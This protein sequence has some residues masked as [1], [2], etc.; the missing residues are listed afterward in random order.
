MTE[1]EKPRGDC[2]TQKKDRFKVYMKTIR[3]AHRRL[4]K[5]A[6]EENRV[7]L[8]VWFQQCDRKAVF[9]LRTKMTPKV[10]R[11]SKRR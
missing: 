1:E 10:E 2:G 8:K 7:S 6:S 11:L 9:Q 5:K 4:Y 3:S